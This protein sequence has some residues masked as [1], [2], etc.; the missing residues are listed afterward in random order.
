MEQIGRIELQRGMDKVF[1][2]LR[3]VFSILYPINHVWLPLVY[4]LLRP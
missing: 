1:H 2:R 3:V 4:H